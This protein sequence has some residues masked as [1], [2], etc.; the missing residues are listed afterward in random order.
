MK[1]I[2]L[3]GAMILVLCGGLLAQKPSFELRC[4]L[5]GSL[6]IWDQRA[7]KTSNGM[8][9][10]AFAVVAGGVKIDKDMYVGAGPLIGASFLSSTASALGYTATGT[11]SL[12]DIGGTII[13]G[14]DDMYLM[15]GIGSADLGLSIEVLGQSETVDFPEPAS[16]QRVTIG[17]GRDF[18]IGISYVSYS[19]TSGSYDYHHLGRF[20][21]NV[22]FLF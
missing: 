22:G 8:G 13:F 6:Q 18:A 16:Y 12:L 20:E 3:I 17:W 4:G 1:K 14:F 9:Y 19:G 21:F 5:L 10:G 7:D 15:I 2:F 11:W